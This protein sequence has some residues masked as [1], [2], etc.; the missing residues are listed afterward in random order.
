MKAW[1]IFFLVVG[2]PVLMLVW[3]IWKTDG[4][5]P[6]GYKD[7]HDRPVIPAV[8]LDINMPFSSMVVFMFKLALAALPAIFL[9]VI[10]LGS[11]AAVTGM[12]LI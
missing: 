12:A 3:H 4:R 10:V 9:I 7:I 6:D 5:R 2:I 1:W 8:I 11:F